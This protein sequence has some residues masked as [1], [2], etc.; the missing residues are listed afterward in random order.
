[1][2]TD[3]SICKECPFYYEEPT[4]GGTLWCCKFYGLK[5]YTTRE[6]DIELIIKAIS[7]CP[8]AKIIATGF[9]TVLAKGK[10]SKG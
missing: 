4:T 2:N 5:L 10:L 9:V 7:N 6:K 3:K 1:M 8:F